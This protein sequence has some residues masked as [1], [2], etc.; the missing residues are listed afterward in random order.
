[1]QFEAFADGEWLFDQLDQMPESLD[2]YDAAHAGV[3]ETHLSPDSHSPLRR[4]PN[5]QVVGGTEQQS[6]VCLQKNGKRKL[7]KAA[8]SDDGTG[9]LKARKKL[10]TYSSK[11]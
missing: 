6:S 10:K 2:T 11:P 3:F 4:G 9:D 1:M 7:D 5:A 8:P